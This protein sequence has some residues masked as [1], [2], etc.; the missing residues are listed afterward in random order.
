M[1]HTIPGT[2]L[3]VCNAEQKIAYNYCFSWSDSLNSNPARYNYII[4]CIAKDLER[5]KDSDMKKYDIDLIKRYVT[6]NLKNYTENFFIATSYA[7]IGAFFTLP[8][9]EEKAS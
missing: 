4:G 1:A 5:R 8:E 9:D 7:Q 2:R 6:H 3:S